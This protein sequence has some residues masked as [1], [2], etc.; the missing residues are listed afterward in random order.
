MTS[1]VNA[2][3]MHRA[4]R[5]YTAKEPWQRSN[6]WQVTGQ[7]TDLALLG[8]ALLTVGVSGNKERIPESARESY[9]VNAD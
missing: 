7:H 1:Q 3:A 6:D 4:V 5:S 9:H 8:T 2:N